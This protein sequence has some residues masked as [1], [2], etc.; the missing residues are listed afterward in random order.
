MYLL[1]R[2]ARFASPEDWSEAEIYWLRRQSNDAVVRVLCPMHFSYGMVGT[3]ETFCS[4]AAASQ[5]ARRA[6]ETAPQQ[7]A[8]RVQ[9]A[10]VV[11]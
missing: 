3:N 6:R 9:C 2:T 11:E 5:E 1:Q 10:N 7:G 4:S 8:L